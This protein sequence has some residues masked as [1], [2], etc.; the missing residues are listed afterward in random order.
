MRELHLTIHGVVQ[1]VSFR[2]YTQKQ[3]QSL[4]LSGYV[5][6][7][8]DGRV[9]V[10][11]QGDEQSLEKLLEW[12]TNGPDHARVEKVESKWRKPETEFAGFE[13]KY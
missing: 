1:G 4:G 10:V 9:E 13:I 8:P 6:N 11:A 12:C 3:A 5:R 2:Y 7:L